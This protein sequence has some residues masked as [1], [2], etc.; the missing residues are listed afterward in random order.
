M[1][2]RNTSALSCSTALLT[3][4]SRIRSKM[5]SWTKGSTE[6]STALWTLRPTHG[7]SRMPAG[8]L[9]TAAS[10]PATLST[11]TTI[12][13]AMGSITPTKTPSS[14]LRTSATSTTKTKAGLLL[15]AGQLSYQKGESSLCQSTSLETP[16]EQTPS[17]H[18]PWMVSY[19]D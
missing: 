6:P 2:F 15:H 10:F 14:A 9:K 5:L 1:I 8:C 18:I 4:A 7:R 17:E 12:S 16:T 19:Q 13:R 11:R 3:T